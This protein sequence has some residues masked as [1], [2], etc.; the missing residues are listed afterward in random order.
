MHHPREIF[1]PNSHLTDCRHAIP[2]TNCQ[3][4]FS[5]PVNDH[6]R[7]IHVLVLS[8][9]CFSDAIELEKFFCGKKYGH[10]WVPKIV[11]HLLEDVLALEEFTRHQ[12]T[13]V[14]FGVSDHVSHSVVDGV[15]CVVMDIRDIHLLNCGGD[16]SWN[17]IAHHVHVVYYYVL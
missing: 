13:V 4:K 14:F 9:G 1:K 5:L 16:H 12:L 10:D 7:Y 6:I 11:Y 15:D 8:V 2:L 3:P 17:C